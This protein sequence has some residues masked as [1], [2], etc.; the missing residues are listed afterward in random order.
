MNVD[1]HLPGFQKLKELF[2]FFKSCC[3]VEADV[4]PQASSH[5]IHKKSNP[6]V[7]PSLTTTRV[8]RNER[9]LTDF[10]LKTA[11]LSAKSNEK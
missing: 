5:M 7:V 6:V 10:G 11:N 3:F 1:T 2:S 9:F 8:R 4:F